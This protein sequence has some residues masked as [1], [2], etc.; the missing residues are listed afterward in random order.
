MFDN[1]NEDHNSVENVADDDNDIEIEA[2]CQDHDDG[3]Y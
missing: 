2:Q 1:E 3:K